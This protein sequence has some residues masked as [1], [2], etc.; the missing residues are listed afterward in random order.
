MTIK[1]AME[2]RHMVRKYTDRKIPEEIV[3]QLTER[4]T[5]NNKKYN[6]NMKSITENTEA[7]PIIIKL[8]LAKGVRNYIILAGEDT[9]DID[10]K[11][12]Y[13]GTDVMLFA[14]TL[15]L[16]SWWIGGDFS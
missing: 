3:N 11:L 15:G 1:E 14:Q 2:N 4:I 13:C 7:I 12:G 9:I 5:K 10:E 8:I 16:N 6:L